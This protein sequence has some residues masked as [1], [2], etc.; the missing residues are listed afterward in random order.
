[1]L[2]SCF[3]E[4]MNMSGELVRIAIAIIGT[5]IA[6]WYDIKNNKNIPDNLLYV[7][8]AIA[9][10][11]NLVFFQ[12]DI[13]IY[14]VFI[15]AIIFLIGYFLYRVGHIG[16]ADIYVLTSIALLVPVFP[17]YISIPFNIPVVIS[18]IIF[19]GILFALYFIY[20]ILAN[21]ILKGKKGKFEY[22]LL[23]PVYAV[24]I[25]FISSVGIFGLMYLITL[26]ILIISLILFMVYKEQI[27]NS[28]ARKVSIS[29]V[30]EED[31]AVLELM[32]LLVKEH[33][34]KRLLD[35]KELARLKQLNIREIYVY[36]ELPPFL[37][38]ILAGLLLSVTVGD[39]FMFI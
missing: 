32:P 2:E 25:Y 30:D 36:K 6:S 27:I 10:I 15:A 31:V 18:I 12:Q 14:S 34:I 21:I 35:A 37:P 39:I 4:K 24:L 23:A 5:A 1:M 20:F 13:F 3:I 11:A 22:L 28:M 29:E 17:S 8:L 7:F 9:F 38:F 16:C 19:S 33:N 26:N